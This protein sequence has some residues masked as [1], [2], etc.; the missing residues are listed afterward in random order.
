MTEALAGTPPRDVTR[1]NGGGGLIASAAPTEITPDT[2]ETPANPPQTI[3]GMIEN[4]LGSNDGL[5][6][7]AQKQQ[8]KKVMEDHIGGAKD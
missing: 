4:I 2:P 1:P 5:D 8:R 6:S 7:E 3:E